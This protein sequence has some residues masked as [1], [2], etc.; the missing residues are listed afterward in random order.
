MLT[1]TRKGLVISRRRHIL[2]NRSH[3]ITK[4]NG[5]S[6]HPL[7]WINLLQQLI[8]PLQLLVGQLV[9]IK[10][11]YIAIQLLIVLKYYLVE[12]HVVVL[13]TNMLHL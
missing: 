4:L 12:L 2:I 10:N 11:K 8:R 13:L 6:I 5:Q 9:L 3:K 1:P 7:R